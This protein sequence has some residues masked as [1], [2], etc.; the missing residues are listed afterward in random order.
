MRKDE[1][2]VKLTTSKVPSTPT[3]SRFIV[4]LNTTEKQGYPYIADV[5]VPGELKE[6]SG[7]PKSQGKI[8]V[9]PQS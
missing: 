4:T 6:T 1:E 9:P 2:T 7:N 5:V 3:Q 8:V